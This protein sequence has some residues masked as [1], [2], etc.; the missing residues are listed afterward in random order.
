MDL[1]QGREI[2]ALGW[3][4]SGGV[5]ALRRGEGIEVEEEGRGWDGVLEIAGLR[6]W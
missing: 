4:R 1:R 3:E 6:W 5:C 2:G